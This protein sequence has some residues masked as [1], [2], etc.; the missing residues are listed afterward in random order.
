M[1]KETLDTKIIDFGFSCQ[2]DYKNE[3]LRSF[4]GTPAYMSPE[5]TAKKDYSGPASDIWASGVL[6]YSLLMGTQPFKA[7]T[8]Q[9]LYRKI[10]KCAISFPKSSH[11]DFSL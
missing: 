3:K 7:K 4:C 1:S 10:Q 9:E 6:L 5:I 8:E 11:P 2:T